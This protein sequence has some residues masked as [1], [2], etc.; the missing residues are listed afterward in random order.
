MTARG[1]HGLGKTALAAWTILW[2]ALTREALAVDWKVATTASAWR[3]LTKYLW[4]E[5][6]KWARRIRWESIGRPPFDERRELLDLSLKLRLGEAFAVASDNAVLIE[7][8]HAT[9]ILYLFDEA[10][11]IPASVWDAAEGA[12]STGGIGASEAYAVAISTPGEP[13]GRFF[14]IHARRAGFEDWSARHVTLSDAIAAGRISP[15]WAEQRAKQWGEASA[16]YRNRVLGE[17]ATADS[18]G[19]VPLEWIEAANERWRTLDEAGSWG[20]LDALGVDVGGSGE[21]ASVIAERIGFAIRNLRMRKGVEPMALVGEVVA[22]LKA[23]GANAHAVVDEIG[24][25]WGISGRLD[26]LGVDV[27]PFIASG[28]ASE[29]RDESGEFGFANVRAAAWWAMREMLNPKSEIPVAL[30]PDDML[31]GDLTAPKY[32]ILSGGRILIESKDEIR[33]RIGRSTDH[34]DAVVMAFWKIGRGAV[35]GETAGTRTAH[36]AFGEAAASDTIAARLA[37]F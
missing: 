12:F 37:G 29:I 1:P 10:K 34:G 32:R 24:V 7:G 25:G 2:F 5:V 27:V 13:N 19:V 21:D 14:E 26:E 4:P 20:S 28:S 6:H 9:S 23:H 3:Q 36:A 11:A 8:A 30:P 18:D 33:K 31:T 22:I 35:D 15:E 17:F 16:V